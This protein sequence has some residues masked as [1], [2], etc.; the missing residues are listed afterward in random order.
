MAYLKPQKFSNIKK[1]ILHV[2]EDLLEG[3]NIGDWWFFRKFVNI[4]NYADKHK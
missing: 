2:Q 4:N 1:H 3:I